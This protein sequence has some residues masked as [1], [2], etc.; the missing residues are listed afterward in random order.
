MCEVMRRGER[1]REKERE[2]ETRSEGKQE[3]SNVVLERRREWVEFRST[4]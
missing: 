2:N 1:E 4:K 3:A